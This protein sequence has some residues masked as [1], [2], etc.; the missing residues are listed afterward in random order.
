MQLN[1]F[2]K[3]INLFTNPAAQDKY[4]RKQII[5]FFNKLICFKVLILPAKGR[6]KPGEIESSKLAN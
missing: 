3:K 1:F 5:L 2:V 6:S 4:L